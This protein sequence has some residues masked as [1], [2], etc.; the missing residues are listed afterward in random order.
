VRIP[1]GLALNPESLQRF[2]SAKEV[3]ERPG[4]DVVDA[5]NSIC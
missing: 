4:H 2:V 1:P 3:F 5:W